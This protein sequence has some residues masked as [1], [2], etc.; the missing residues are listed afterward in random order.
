MIWLYQS[1]LTG[2]D[3]TKQHL[4]T[5]TAAALL[6][7]ATLSITAG[8]AQAGFRTESVLV[9][10][11][12]TPYE[13]K[14]TSVQWQTDKAENIGV[15]VT[16]GESVL[17]PS[18]S[19]VLRLS[20]ENGL[21][22][23]SVK[24][25]EEICTGYSGVM[26]GDILIQ[27]TASGLCTIDFTSGTVT[28]H[29]S[30]GGS[31]DSDVALIDGLAYFSVKDG[32]CES[33]C[34]ADT[35]NMSLKWK[36]TAQADITSATVQGDYVI[37]GAGKNLVT[38]HYK[39]GT[40]CEIPLDSEVTSAPFAT[41]YAV[42][43]AMGGSTAKLR[44]NSDGTYEDDTLTLC[45]T[46]EN[47]AAPVVYNS[48][49]Y[50][51]SDSGFHILDSLNMEITHTL[52]EITGG[53]DPIVTYGTGTRI[54]TVGKYQDRWALYCVFDAS[55]EHE[56]TSTTL[57]GLDDFTGGRVSISAEGTMYFR[58]AH[59]RLFAVTRVAYSILN[60]V[61]KLVV[62]LAIIVGVFI[63]LKLIAKRREDL[64]PKY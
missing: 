52:S 18:G 43:F 19:S 58:D 53:S 35:S 31:V 55:E 5:K 38:C 40:V 3:I 63:W 56:P 8:A 50:T 16:Y 10:P 49:L 20:E 60:I 57:A 46:G 34:C 14:Y 47:T 6:T 64:Y 62:L 15:P 2:S 45:E 61:L 54:Y 32:D 29:K 30:F 33:F 44:L 7:A 12:V 9:S 37:F 26:S 13:G 23:A 51:V 24:L 22:L 48:R 4:L 36:Y 17:L 21:E 25:P 27:P 1:D 28:A 11:A 41:E 59:G 42:F 39:D